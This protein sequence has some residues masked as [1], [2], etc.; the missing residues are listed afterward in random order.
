MNFFISLC[1]NPGCRSPY[2]EVL[3]ADVSK[4]RLRDLSESPQAEISRQHHLKTF[5]CVAQ[6]DA[7]EKDVKTS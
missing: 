3:D 7:W 1:R 4:K 6:L 5:A 2:I